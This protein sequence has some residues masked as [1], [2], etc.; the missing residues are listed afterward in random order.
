MHTTTSGGVT[1][2]AKTV[3]QRKRAVTFHERKMKNSNHRTINSYLKAIIDIRL[4][5]SSGGASSWVI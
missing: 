2:H 4:H 5:P 3:K 1:R